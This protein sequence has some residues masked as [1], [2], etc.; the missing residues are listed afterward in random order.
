[1]KLSVIVPVYNG[2]KYLE[3]CLSS[4]TRQGF[5]K[6][7][8][9]V[10]VV[11]DG[12]TDGTEGII[13]KFCSTYGYFLKVNKAKGG[14]SSARNLGIEYAIES[15]A[16][17]VAFLDGDDIFQDN[18]Y[19]A[20]LEICYKENLDGYYFKWTRDK[21]LFNQATPERFSNYQILPKKHAQIITT[22]LFRLSIIK[23]NNIR[24]DTILKT[25]EDTLFSFDFHRK[26]KKVAF[27]EIHPYYYSDNPD[28]VMGKIEHNKTPGLIR[29]E[30]NQLFDKVRYS[31]TVED[32]GIDVEEWRRWDSSRWFKYLL[33]EAMKNGYK[34][35]DTIKKMKH[36]QIKFSYLNKKDFKG[37]C[38][39]VK[40]KMFVNWYFLRYSLLYRL[41]CWYYRNVKRR[42][43][44]EEKQT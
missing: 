26:V 25:A 16:D 10:I 13:D 21:E 2:E 17:Y 43:P 35:K 7:E 40:V 12:S 24:F 6:G 9:Q 3:E 19:L 39:S 41:G 5:K 14:V 23:E 15:N 29:Q 1:M 34:A 31:R 37:W 18:A 8:H 11:N 44:P 28:S 33:N 32:L 36:Y 42:R 30:Y 22:N 38:R 27:L 4:L 20:I